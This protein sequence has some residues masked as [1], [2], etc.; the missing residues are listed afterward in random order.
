M[1]CTNSTCCFSVELSFFDPKL[2]LP[3][4]HAARRLLQKKLGFRTTFDVVPLDA[5]I[6]KGSHGLAAS[7]PADRPILI[8]HGPAP[9]GSVPMTRVK[10]LLLREMEL[11]PT[12]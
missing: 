10:E 11:T 6:V 3:K 4:L 2:M 8:G 7:D 1:R 9:A 12:A 5:G